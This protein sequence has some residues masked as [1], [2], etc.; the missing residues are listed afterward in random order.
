MLNILTLDITRIDQDICI[1]HSCHSRGACNISNVYNFHI[2]Y[3]KLEI[4]IYYIKNCSEIQKNNFL[5]L[6]QN[7]K[8]NS[9]NCKKNP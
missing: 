1:K 9:K 7:C 6:P 2:L 5:K 3:K 4:V 8:E